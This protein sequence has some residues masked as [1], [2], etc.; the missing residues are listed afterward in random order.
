LQVPTSND[1]NGTSPEPARSNYYILRAF[2]AMLN[3]EIPDQETFLDMI[4]LCSYHI[5]PNV[6]WSSPIN[7]Q[8][9]VRVVQDKSTLQGIL[10][11]FEDYVVRITPNL[12]KFPA[13]KSGNTSISKSSTVNRLHGGLKPRLGYGGAKKEILEEDIR[14]NWKNSTKVKCL[15]MV[16]FM[17]CVFDEQLL[18]RYWNIVTSFV[19]NLGDDHEPLI[20]YQSMK[21]ES[22][23][24]D[25]VADSKHILV[26]SGLLEVFIESNKKALTH[27]PPITPPNTSMLVLR[28]AYSCLD[29]LLAIKG[30]SSPVILDYTELVSIYILPSISNLLSRSEKESFLPVIIIL[31]TELQHL[32]NNRLTFKVMLSVSRINFTLNQTITNPF[33]LDHEHGLLAVRKCL[34][35]QEAILD[36]IAKTEEQGKALLLAYKYDFIGSWA[37][38]VKR[39]R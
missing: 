14:R 26:K 16:W 34:Q 9:M 30:V 1:W 5:N 7:S 23:F 2:W 32:I 38:L 21:L 31:L 22:Y 29:C 25:K 20:K 6:P 13:I 35:C 17:V 33:I 12:L 27:T 15:S 28:E 24:L 4:E 37:V 18:E 19:L 8:L 11:H 36:Q 3:R 10:T 39:L